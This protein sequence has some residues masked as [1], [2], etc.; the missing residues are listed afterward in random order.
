MGAQANLNQEGMRIDSANDSIVI[1]NYGAGIKGG[2]TLDMSDFPSDLK[3][4]RAGHIVIRSTV[5]ETLYKPMPVAAGG[6][7][8]A[9]LP[10]NYE[11]VGVVVATKPVDYPLVGIM[12][13]GEVND[14]ASPYPVTSIKAALKTALPG[15]VFMHD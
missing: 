13:A 7:A 1:R 8:Y 3:C 5:D 10:A 15:L 14:V 12:Y 6:Q 11:Y 4:I 2:R 9:S